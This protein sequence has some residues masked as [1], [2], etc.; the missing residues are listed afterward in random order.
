[1]TLRAKTLLILGVALVTLVIVLNVS[2]SWIVLRGFDQLEEQNSRESLQRGINAL[3]TEF[4]SLANLVGDWSVWDDAYAFMQ[5]RNPAFIRSNLADES[6]GLLD[7]DMVIFVAPDGEILYGQAYDHQAGQ[8][9]PLPDGLA[10]PY[11]QPGSRLLQQEAMT[12]TAGLVLLPQGPLLLVGHPVLT[13]SGDGPARGTILMGRYLD[14]AR[15]QRLADGAGLDLAVQR[16][17]GPLAGDFAAPGPALQ[18]VMVDLNTLAEPPAGSATQ[19]LNGDLIASYAA[20]ADINGRPSLVL[21]SQQH[22]SIYHQGQASSR[23]LLITTLLIGLIFGILAFYILERLVLARVSRLGQSIEGIGAGGG[24][25]QRVPVEGHDELGRLA[26][27]LNHALAALEKT[28]RE[29]DAAA[30]ALTAERNLLRTLIDIMPDYIY[31]KDTAG[32][33]MFTNTAHAVPLGLTS[34]EEA[35]GMTDF[36][37]FPADLATQYA[38]GEA[39]VLTEGKLLLNQLEPVTEPA[40]GERRWVETTKVPLH[41]P[42]GAIIGLVGISR[43]ITERRRTA[44]ALAQANLELQQA[45]ATA[46]DLAAAA[47][48]ATRAKSEFLANM[49][50]EIRTPMNA[51]IGMT[52]LLLDTPLS[53]EQQEYAETIRSSGDTLLTIINDILDFSKIDAGKLEL[54]YQPFDLRAGVEEA[55]DLFAAQAAEKGVELAYIL[56]D[57][58][59][60]TIVG[61]VTRLRQILANLL[62]NAIKFTDAG[63]VVLSILAQKLDGGQYEIHFGVRDTGI[64]IPRDRMDRLFQSFTQIDA[65]TTRRF[66]GTGLGLVISKCLAELM[67]GRMWAESQGIPG[68]G[69]TFHFTIRAQSAA[70]QTR[71]Y[72]RNPQ[73]ELSGKRLLIVDDNATN[74]RI[75]A[76]QAQSW[77]MVVRMAASGPEALNWIRRGDTFD[78]GILDMHMPNMNGLTLAEEIRKYHDAASLPLIMLTSLGTHDKAAQAASAHF[79]AYLTKPIKPSLLQEILLSVFGGRPVVVRP[80]A[81]QPQINTRLARQYPLR[82]LIAEDNALNQKLMLRV[83]AKMGYHPDVAANGLEV[84]LALERQAYD[85]IFMDVQMPEMD[86]LETARQI[87]RTLAA[88]SRPTIVAMTAAAMQ[89]DRDLCLAAGMDDYIAKPVRVEELQAVL[90]RW[91][92]HRSKLDDR[93]TAAE[94]KHAAAAGMVLDPAVIA[95]LRSLQE[96]N[97][98]AVLT[99]MI[100]MFLQ[101]APARLAT[102]HQAA[103]SGDVATVAWAAHSL[104]GSSGIFGAQ[105]MVKLC[106]ELQDLAHAEAR[107]CPEPEVEDDTLIR[108]VEVLAE[109]FAR[110][111]IELRK[112]R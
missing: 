64:G 87:V 35:V 46:N 75:L 103:A 36:D 43:D 25:S 108:M 111:Q 68:Q 86:G 71:V 47:Q 84:L 2:S 49:S 42:E 40:T 44:E 79:A 41:N 1:M 92:K 67:G 16:V 80:D 105:R 57:S 31:A 14:A 18:P 101:N 73:P 100:D 45:V 78:V 97:D 65:S 30:A 70:S 96:E 39:P 3:A 7:A 59:P 90:E 10:T 109:E 95:E 55:L 38:A 99:E 32:R 52:G 77:G 102:L 91:G 61:D 5:D 20:L 23:F 28:Q 26:E 34:P 37:L 9:I 19:R 93:P 83:L 72:L 4:R 110:V 48:S 24:L 15:L 94:V 74:R 53:A 13:S 21:R 62:G 82:I 27:T 50:H 51:V 106:Q 85:L 56:D 63:E 29:H 8:V 98:P 33:F 58:V 89:G 107:D 66:G 81:S 6:Y 17:D 60:H 112:L 104:K 12:S 11:L 69:S 22:R 88:D 76:L 54:E